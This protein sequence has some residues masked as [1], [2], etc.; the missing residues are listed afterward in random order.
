MDGDVKTYTKEE[1]LQSTEPYETLYALIDDKFTLERELIKMSEMA[2]EVG[3]RNFKTLFKAYCD[4]QKKNRITDYAENITNFEGQPLELNSGVWV[5]DDYCISREGPFGEVVACVHPIMPVKRLVNIDTGIE[6]LELAYRKG[7]SWRKVICDRKQLASSNNIIGLADYGVAVTSENA[8][9]LV[10]YIHDVENLNYED[11]P[12]NKSVSRLGWIDEEGFSPYV[13]NLIFD[14]D[15]SFKHYFESVSEKGSYKK[16]LEVV[17]EIRKGSIPARIMLA[18]SFASVLVEPCGG[19]PFFVHLWGG[20][21]T[22]KTVGLMLAASVW[23][24]PEMGKYI[25]TFNSTA[26]AQELSAGFV[27]SLPL[28]LDEL[29]IVKDKRDFDNMIYQLSE[30]VGRA[31]GQKTGGLQR[32]NTWNNCILTTGEQPISSGSSGAGAINRIIEISCEDTKLFADP[33]GLV[34]VIRKNYG[35]AGKRFIAKLQEKN[36]LETAKMLQKEIYKDIIKKDTTEKQTMAASLILT[37]DTLIDLWIFEDGQEMH[38]KDLTEFLSTKSEVSANERAYN[39]V[40]EWI[41]QNSNKFAENNIEEWGKKEDDTVCII[42]NIF[43]KALSENGFNPTSF[44]HWLRRK[45]YIETPQ[46]G[47]TKSKRI[48]GIPCHCVVLKIGKDDVPD[49]FE[50]VFIDDPF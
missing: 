2:Q 10:T 32:T 7:R 3:V 4:L 39:F 24:N 26:V 25:H 20:T 21:E 30:G 37:A 18:A 35:F 12:E 40:F 13:E 19:L 28:I 33:V 11:I 34:E 6:K 8:K 15:I 42:R 16:W 44:L 29:Q 43:D 45:D 22:G 36:G 47:F 49:G 9:H 27:N 48:G 1:F 31:R 14:G 17:R 50:Q 5:A 46:K 38:Y 41:A 23:A